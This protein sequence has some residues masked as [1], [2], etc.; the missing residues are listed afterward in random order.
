MN[1]AQLSSPLS[2]LLSELVDGA[3][4][5][6]AYVLNPGDQGLLRSLDRLSAEAVSKI[7]H[8]GASIAAHTDHLRYGL[9]LMNRW[10]SG[11]NPFAD[12]D[13]GSSWRRTTVSEE[14]WADLRTQLRVEAH[15]WQRALSDPR[16]IDEIEV[17]GVI[18]SIVHLAYHL[19]AIRQ[20]D[21]TAR[22]P[23]NDEA[24]RR[25]EGVS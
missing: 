4:V 6:G 23:S 5:T 10:A 15:L 7:W 12:A 9:S 11:E 24:V 18:G 13:W 25:E 16:E 1:L 2:T 19:G 21:R 3:P 17:N 8:G 22:G 20:I 14:E